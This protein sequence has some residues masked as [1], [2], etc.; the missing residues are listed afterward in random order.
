LALSVRRRTGSSAGFPKHAWESQFA[1]QP[2]QSLVLATHMLNRAILP[3]TQNSGNMGKSAKI[4]IK[5]QDP[6]F[7]MV[8]RP[9]LPD[10]IPA[11]CQ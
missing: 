11:D 8:I 3:E 4:L 9:Q 10:Q 2:A 5:G 7:R 1:Y 6:G